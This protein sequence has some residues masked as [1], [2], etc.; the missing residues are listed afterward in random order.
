MADQPA[1]QGET[2]RRYGGTLKK[3]KKAQSDRVDPS[4]STKMVSVNDL[5]GK[6][7]GGFS[8]PVIDMG[9]SFTSTSSAG[10]VTM[11]DFHF[12]A[13]N[14]IFVPVDEDGQEILDEDDTRPPRVKLPRAKRWT[15]ASIFTRRSSDKL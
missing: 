6:K 5:F 9:A 3:L 13:D 1:T 8:S 4:A 11:D 7:T 12:G 14:P 2:P 10:G 15:F